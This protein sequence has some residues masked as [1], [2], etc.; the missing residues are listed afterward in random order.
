MN[1]R[2]SI[3]GGS[4]TGISFS[5]CHR[6]QTS[7]RANPASYPMGMGVKRPEREAIPPSLRYI[8]VAWS[9][10]KHRDFTFTKPILTWLSPIPDVFSR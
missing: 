6:P 9:L 2:G 10:I 1:D 4:D 5:L 8:F 3:P 7:P